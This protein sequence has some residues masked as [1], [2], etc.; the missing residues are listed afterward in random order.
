MEVLRC[1]NVFDYAR[2]TA[3]SACARLLGSRKARLKAMEEAILKC[4]R[5]SVAGSAAVVL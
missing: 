5:T 1:R 2:A 4:V 3:Q